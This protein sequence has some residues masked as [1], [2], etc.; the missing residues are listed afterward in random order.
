[1]TSANVVQLQVGPRWRALI[2]H[3]RSDVRHVLRTL[4]EAS[5]V[6]VVEAFDGDSALSRLETMRFDLLVLELDLPVRDGVTLVQLHRVLLAHE[7]APVE[8][9]DVILTLP[10]EVRDNRTLIEHLRSLGV[11][12]VIDDSP[13]AD[14]A[15]VIESTLQARA[16]RLAQKPAVA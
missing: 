10:P 8:P 11:A 2:A 1:M 13:R 12:A 7:R 3:Q 16:E 6:A 4:I 5:D 14:A 15:A 9:P